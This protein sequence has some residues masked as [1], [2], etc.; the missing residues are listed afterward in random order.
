VK[1]TLGMSYR[2]IGKVS[3]S[4]DD[5][6]NLLKKQLAAAKYLELLG[7]KG[8]VFN[9]DESILR[10][11]DQRRRSWCSM[12]SKILVSHSRRLS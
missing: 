3:S 7:E 5:P 9:I 1:E 2:I 11:T 10:T 12:R 8:E 4:Y 6:Q